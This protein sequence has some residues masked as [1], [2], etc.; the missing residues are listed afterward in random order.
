MFVYFAGHGSM[1][2]TTKAMLNGKRHYPLEKSLRNL[3]KCDGSYVMGVFDCCREKLDPNLAT[4]GGGGAMDIDEEDMDD[5]VNLED[6]QENFIM[7]YG[8]QPSS[9]VP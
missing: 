1:D 6:S 5:A 3:A 4:R 9:G 2:N 7:T 8:C